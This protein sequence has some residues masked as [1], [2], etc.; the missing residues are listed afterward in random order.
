MGEGAGTGGKQD[1]RGELSEL[2][3]HHVFGD[4]HVVIYLSVVDLELESY[5]VWQYRRRSGR[6]FDGRGALAGFGADDGKTGDED[7]EQRP[8]VLL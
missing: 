8:Y 4:G 5:E 3:S 1:L 2:V 7:A 6:G